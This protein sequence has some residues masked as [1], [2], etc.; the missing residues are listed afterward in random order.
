VAVRAGGARRSRRR[1]GVPLPDAETLVDPPSPPTWNL[2]SGG[3]PF[4]PMSVESINQ[5][6][7]E[8]DP[9]VPIKMFAQLLAQ[10][11]SGGDWSKRARCRERPSWWFFPV[12]ELI[13]GPWIRR[14]RWEC[15]RCPVR[16]ECLSSALE[17]P[18][19]VG[20]WGGTTRDQRTAVAHLPRWRQIVSLNRQFKVMATTGP[21][22]VA[23]KNEWVGI[24]PFV[25]SV[26][27]T[28]T[29]S[30]TRSVSVT[31]TALPSVSKESLAS[32]AR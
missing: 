12:K 2:A 16:L 23:T 17:S 7:E 31:G 11:A 19:T 25:S 18:K 15:A 4:P 3:L 20:V 27:A 1:G 21:W 32:Q 13:S 9:P 28:P 22:R 26:S 24:P 6:L 5:L 10:T 8:L 30:S 14:A 29:S